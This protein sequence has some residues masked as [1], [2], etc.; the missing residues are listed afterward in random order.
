M[1][2]TQKKP[3]AELYLAGW[4]YGQLANKGKKRTGE[5]K[6]ISPPD[7]F[8]WQ[9]STGRYRSKTTGKFVAE[10]TVQKTIDQY[11]EQRTVPY[12]AQVTQSFIDGK[13]SL[14]QWQI[15]MALE[16][17]ES[18]RYNLLAARGGKNNVTWSDWGRM[19]ARLAQDYKALINFAKQIKGGMLSEA[20]IKARIPLYSNSTK[21]AYQDGRQQTKKEA[22]FTKMRRRTTPAEHCA[23]CIDYEAQGWVPIGTLPLPGSGSICGS[24]CKCVVEYGKAEESEKAGEVIPH[25]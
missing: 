6:Y 23:D 14:G 15:K 8:T 4:L 9:K 3:P 25:E 13:L 11:H 20:Q 12:M 22:G 17:K 16:M 1:L 19:G 10:A 2:T 24:N 5:G 21:L 18:Y 7:K